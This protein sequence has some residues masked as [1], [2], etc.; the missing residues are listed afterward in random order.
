M[1]ELN[2]RTLESLI[3][4]ME[5]TEKSETRILTEKMRREIWKTTFDYFMTNSSIG[6]F[7]VTNASAKADQAVEAF[8]AKF[9][10]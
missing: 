6:Q 9:R 1:I 10:V 3:K 5:V 7:Q 2:Q 4:K 8:D